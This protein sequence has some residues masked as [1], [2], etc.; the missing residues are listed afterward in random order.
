MEDLD[1]R[2][3]VTQRTFVEGHQRFEDVRLGA[4]GIVNRV[5]DAMF[6]QMEYPATLVLVL[7]QRRNTIRMTR[8]RSGTDFS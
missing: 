2:S 7:E 1:L 6:E 4:Q 5:L 3:I 8:E